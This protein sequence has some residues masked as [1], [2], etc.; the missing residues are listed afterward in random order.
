MQLALPGNPHLTYCSNIH[1]GESWGEIE[2]NL[3]DFLPRVKRRVSPDAPMGVGLRLSGDAAAEL[4]MPETLRA[5]HALLDREGLYVFTINAFPY[6][7]FHGQRVKEEVY[8][9][10]WREPERLRFTNTCA[11]ILSA[12]LPEGQTG[13]IS[14]VPGAFKPEITTDAGRALIAEQ[15]A[16]A[17]AHLH[18]I[19]QE[20]G[21]KIVLAIE[22][23]PCCL[24]ETT[25]E[26]VGFFED[27]LFGSAGVAQMAKETGLPKREAREALARHIGLCFDVCHAAVE[28]EDIAASVDALDRAGIA[29]AK[30]QLS[31]AI[32]V[33]RVGDDIE[34][35]LAPFDEGVYLHQTV[36]RRNGELTRLTDL[37]DAFVA[38]RQ[39]E[40]MHS[41]WRV[42]CHVPVFLERFEGIGS[43]QAV[44]KEALALCRERAISPHLEIETYTWSVLPEALRHAELSDD[45]A[46][47]IEWVREELQA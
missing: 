26:A 21:K 1:P 19:L 29:I 16:S 44:L 37:P 18:G 47:E 36:A 15:M 6:G 43:T 17:A 46:R 31:A 39:G 38:S 7:P 4:R 2:A 22:P 14:T 28:F 8:K 34:S 35:L 24:M 9:P 33:P 41:E 10:D 32:R 25:E 5:L 40:L 30:L 3:R 12:L 27:D 42:H 45:I 13:T 20:T 23:E 11:D